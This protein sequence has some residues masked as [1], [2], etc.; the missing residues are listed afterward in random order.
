MAGTLLVV[1]LGQE[2]FVFQPPNI[3]QKY[4]ERCKWP[5]LFASIN[6]QI[7]YVPVESEKSLRMAEMPL[8]DDYGMIDGGHQQR[9]PW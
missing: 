8:E 7:V 4:T 1:D 3:I 2:S 9:P 6:G 5:E